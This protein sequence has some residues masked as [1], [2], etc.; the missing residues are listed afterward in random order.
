MILLY[1]VLSN[2]DTIDHNH[3][4]TDVEKS[5][6]IFSSMN[7]VTVA[8]RCAEIVQEVLDIAKKATQ[9][10]EPG[11]GLQGPQNHPAGETE[12]QSES[13]LLAEFELSKEDLYAS[14][15]DSNLMDGFAPFDNGFFDIP[16]FN[17]VL[18]SGPFS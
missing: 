17:S 6:E 15:V 1:V 10:P 16:D 7:M 11:E 2:I 18:G 3:A 8:R 14:L 9:A 5:L 13:D 4:I 12:L